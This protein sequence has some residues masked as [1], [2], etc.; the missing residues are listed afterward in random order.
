M[1]AIDPIFDQM[2]AQGGTDLHIVEGQP[3]RIRRAGHLGGLPGFDALQSDEVTGMLRE[4]CM[5][6]RWHRFERSGDLD[7][8][9][10]YENK[11]RFRANY[12]RQ[13]HGCGAVFRAIP[14]EIMS[15]DDL[16]VPDVF[17]NFADYRTG[18]IMVTSP[19]GGGKSTTAAAIL[20]HINST[21]AR[22]IMTVEEPV[23]FVHPPKKS[24][25]VQREVGVNTKEFPDAIAA[26]LRQD[27]DVIFVGEMRDLATIDVTVTAAETG[28]LVIATLYTDGAVKT[29]DRI[30]DVFP[31]KQQLSIR[32]S[33]AVSLKAVCSQQL[34]RRAD[35]EGLIAA[36]EIL[37]QTL[38]VSNTIREGKTQMLNQI[39]MS[40]RA[41][42]M[43]LMDDC[44][45]AYVQQNLIK[46]VEA[47]YKCHDKERF[48]QYSPTSTRAY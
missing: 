5:P 9:H 28:A 1:A 27:V 36:F 3:P 23:E 13:I 33:L 14:S 15:L 47:W 37:L 2:L 26:A 12:H 32:Q 38:A 7:F 30:I 48:E 43:R 34:C 39:M 41:I 19:G 16:E 21:K 20:D 24:A 17:K 8:I 25:I 46:G 6:E 22:H 29:V 44:L 31:A 11:A 10:V 40:S 18:M 45:E 4:I 35:G 42:G